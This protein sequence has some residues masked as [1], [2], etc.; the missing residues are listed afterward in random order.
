[1]S[2]G[3][4]ADLSSMGDEGASGAASAG[5][6]KPAKGGKGKAAAPPAAQA[7]PTRPRAIDPDTGLEL[8]E[9]GL[10][11]SGPARRQWLARAG[12]DDPALTVRDTETEMKND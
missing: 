6:V 1:M 8:D 3:D 5:D 9:Y 10:P 2:G 4:P 7:A 11:T 12:I